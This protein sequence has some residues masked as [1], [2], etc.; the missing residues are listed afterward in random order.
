M[1]VSIIK[2]TVLFLCCF[3]FLALLAERR[4][5]PIS[6]HLGFVL[7]SALLCLE[8]VFLKLYCPALSYIL[9][10]LTFFSFSLFF[11]RVAVR[12]CFFLSVMI[13]GM[14]FIIFE[15]AL[16]LLAIISY[17][18][19]F[20]KTN[21]IIF[22]IIVAAL[23]I[24]PLLLYCLTHIKKFERSLSVL[25]SRVIVAIGFIVSCLF[26][27]VMTIE[28]ISINTFSYRR[29]FRMLLI[30]LSAVILVLWWRR[31]IARSYREKLRLLEV[32]TLRA[33]MR[34]MEQYIA[35]LEE[36]NKR[37]GHIIH[38]DNRIVTAMADSVIEFLS[39][40]DELPE[41]AL[42]AKGKALAQEL[43]NMQDAR[44]A[45]FTDRATLPDSI[46]QTGF[47]G[48]DALI[49]YMTKEAARH[50]ISLKFHFQ[51]SFFTS[52]KPKMEESDLVHLISDL[53]EN[54]VIAT[55]HANGSSMELSML[56]IK[57]IPTLSLS[58]SGIPFAID[59]YLKFGLAKASTHLEEG[60]SGIG[61]MDIW[62][63]K[64]ACRASL[65]IEEYPAG[66]KF[67][68]R[69][70]LLFDRKN[71]YIIVSPRAKEITA[72]QTRRDLLVIDTNQ[73]SPLG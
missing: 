36:D 58:D 65:S 40:A 71:R 54:A 55:T 46:P 48:I 61:L 21:T 52:A 18:F 42:I 16:L 27:F 33:S 62:Q 14:N 29:L 64:T 20:P 47:L 50:H 13:Y 10:A 49:S 69:I 68:K 38:K 12:E 3:Y 24:L 19:G 51:P 11:F 31:Q 57:G 70:S 25:H 5:L 8:T 1:I 32:E 15:I 73:E 39:R 45:L 41:E 34:D 66:E 7:S 63:L 22:Q 26:I 35:K 9:P 30:S 56:M 4:C 59:T 17:L 23:C 2:N 43:T 6:T 72:A 37:M 60:G 44:Q 53:L 67:T 28:Q